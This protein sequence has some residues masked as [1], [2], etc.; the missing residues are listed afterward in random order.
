MEL[1]PVFEPS[2][3]DQELEKKNGKTKIGGLLYGKNGK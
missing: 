3:K 1:D 2:L